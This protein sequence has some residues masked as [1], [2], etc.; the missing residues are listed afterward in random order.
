MI[1]DSQDPFVNSYVLTA[2]D[3]HSGLY[4]SSRFLFVGLQQASLKE[5]LKWG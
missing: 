2:Q 5:K 1:L 4:E 3:G